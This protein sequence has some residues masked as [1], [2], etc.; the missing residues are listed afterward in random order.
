VFNDPDASPAGAPDSSSS[1]PAHSPDTDDVGREYIEQ[2]RE[3]LAREAG[4]LPL[5]PE[6]EER[7]RQAIECAIADY[8]A[9]YAPL[10]GI[11]TVRQAVQGAVSN[12]LRRPRGRPPLNRFAR[13]EDEALLREFESLTSTREYSDSREVVRLLC[14]KRALLR[15]AAERMERG[16]SLPEPD[17]KLPLKP[18]EVTAMERRLRHI[19]VRMR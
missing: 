18:N 7:A 12:G 15:L 8:V 9:T 14:E 4:L 6:N 16:E 13:E 19:K 2:R 11:K 5:L 3:K 10:V 1:S 17:Y